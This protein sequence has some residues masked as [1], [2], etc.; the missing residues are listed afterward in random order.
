MEARYTVLMSVY[1]KEKNEYLT[2]SLDSIVAQSLP[3]S[4]LVLVCDGPLTEALDAVIEAF[5]E[6]YPFLDVVKLPKNVGQGPAL[7]HGLACCQNELIIRMDSD[8]IAFSDRCEKQLR[9]MLENSLD[10]CSAAVDEFTGDRRITSRRSLPCDYD[11]LMRFARLRNPINHPCAA[12]RKSMVEKVGGY[13]HM[14]LFEDYDLWARMILT[15]A[16]LGN[17]SEPLLFMRAGSEFYSRRSGFT[18]CLNIISFWR[19]M[20][21]IGFCGPLRAWMNTVGRC[22]ISL[23]P[24]RW[25]VAV[26]GKLLRK[27]AEKA[28]RGV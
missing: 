16:R 23:L 27:N 4:Q 20:R 21:R 12:F 5:E 15:G 11:V 7:N 24:V 17:L 28:R 2:A 25:V 18:Y 26:Y 1:A 8:D 19:E 14:P 3:P 13:R 9:Y 22:A 10:L 6:R